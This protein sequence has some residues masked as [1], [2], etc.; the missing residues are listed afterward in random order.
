MARVKFEDLST[1]QQKLANKARKKLGLDP[2]KL[3]SLFVNRA[4]IIRQQEIDA[5]EL[6]K[7]RKR[8]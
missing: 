3:A 8:G 6:R 5:E 7:S 4:K 1:R 2:I